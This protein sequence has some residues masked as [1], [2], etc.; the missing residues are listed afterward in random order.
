MS[1]ASPAR[2]TTPRPGPGA[3]DAEDERHVR[4]QPVAHAEHRGAG[5]AAL[6][7]AVVVLQA[8]AAGAVSGSPWLNAIGPVR[9]SRSRGVERCTGIVQRPEGGGPIRPLARPTAVPA[10]D[11]RPRRRLARG[12]SALA[13]LLDGRARYRVD[14]VWDGL[15]EQARRSD[16]MT[17]APEGAAGPA[18]RRAA[19]GAGAGHRVDQRRRRHREVALGA[20][21]RRDRS[22]P[23]SCTTRDRSRCA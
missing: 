19:A 8:G 16:E 14:Q 9:R 20:R 2:R 23:C 17:D 22:R 11:L 4:H 6:D 10:V 21:R 12:P 7:V 1:P 5:R 18:G 3:G 13:E 15:Y